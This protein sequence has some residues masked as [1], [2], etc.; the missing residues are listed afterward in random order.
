MTRKA[1]PKKGKP[2]PVVA[3]IAVR[4]MVAANQSY[5]EPNRVFASRRSA[6]QHADQLNRELR[7]LTNPF[8]DDMEPDWLATGGE[9]GLI[10]LLKKLRAPVPKVQKGDSYIDWEAW[11]DRHYFDMTDAQRDAIWD[12]LD[13]FNWYQVTKTTLE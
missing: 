4:E 8:A 9:D 6:Q 1:T 7:D 10:A 5:T 13:K 2:K 12:A 3:Y 11:W